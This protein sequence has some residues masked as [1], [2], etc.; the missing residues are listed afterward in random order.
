MLRGPKG[1]VVGVAVSPDGTTLA[2]AD[3]QGT[4]TFWEIKSSIAGPSG[5]RTLVFGPLAFALGGNTLATG[6]FDGT[7]KLWN[8]PRSSDE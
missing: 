6:G 5:S 3:F 1:P 7:I 8:S 2:A 4:V